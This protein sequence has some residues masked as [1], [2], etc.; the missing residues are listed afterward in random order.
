MRAPLG[1]QPA[2][3]GQHRVRQYHSRRAS[4][5]RVPGQPRDRAPHP[6]LRALERAGHGAARQQGGLQPRRPHRQLRL[7]GDA[8][9]RRLQPLLACAVGGPRRRPGV[10]PGPLGARHLRARL[11]ARGPAHR[12]AAATTSARRSTARASR[13][14]RTRG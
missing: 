6:R 11:H 14:T 9:R 5:V 7:G 3:L 1:H 2:V 8:V 12:G 4:E 10:H 13:P